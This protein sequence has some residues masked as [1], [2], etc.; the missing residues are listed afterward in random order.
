[1]IF[2]KP[3]PKKTILKRSPLVLLGVFLLLLALD[4]DHHKY[5]SGYDGPLP[6]VQ[7]SF[8]NLT[9]EQIIVLEK[10]FGNNK[11]FPPEAKTAALI[12]LSHYPELK[13]VPIEFVR[14][15]ALMPALSRPKIWG[16]L[17]PWVERK[18]KVIL[19]S[20]AFEGAD[21]VLFHNISL[22]AQIGVIGH[23][24]GHTSYYLDKN[25]FEIVGI[26][27]KYVFSSRFRR[28]FERDTDQGTIERN[29]GPQLLVWTNR[30]FSSFSLPD[31]PNRLPIVMQSYLTPG[32]IEESIEQQNQ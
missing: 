13:D 14:E 6:I 30:I 20:E 1:M 29:L 10:E 7:E 24:I 23:E 11:I 15:P 9:S 21:P 12:A 27:L 8:E 19:A 32:E 3:W 25:A 17:F 22:D 26:G 4:T 5:S 28:T 18:Y 31:D 16:V 2:K